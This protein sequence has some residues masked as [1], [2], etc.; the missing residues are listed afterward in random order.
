MANILAV[1]A[2]LWLLVL[3]IA[4]VG[5]V[6]HLGAMQAAGGSI[7]APQSGLLFDTDG[8]WIPSELPARATATFRSAG[9]DMDDLTIAFFSSRCAP[10][11]ERATSIASALME[12]TGALMDP[13]G[14]LFL[15]T[16]SE[17]G[18]L[19]VMRRILEPTGVPV[20]TDPRAHDIVKA[21]DINSTP[22]AFRVVN[23][24]V[25]AKAYLREVADYMQVVTMAPD[26]ML[27]RAVEPGRTEEVA[28][29]PHSRAE[30]LGV[31]NS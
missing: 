17:S 24:T 7:Q 16:G 26:D 10:C 21:L 15:V 19:D 31:R 28:M 20:L 14:K 11:L 30:V 12:P 27:A 4:F 2:L 13:K 29:G 3:T 8:P 23:K 18:D 22:F 6:R 1:A 25:V 5:V 9:I